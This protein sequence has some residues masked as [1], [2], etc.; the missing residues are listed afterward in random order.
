MHGRN[1]C[2]TFDPMLLLTHLRRFDF[3]QE[4]YTSMHASQI[5]QVSRGCAWAFHAQHVL[6]HN[7][8]KHRVVRRVRK[9]RAASGM[10][11]VHCSFALQS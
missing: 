10:Y 4:W 6:F 1:V 8:C 5:M 11:V 7:P 9:G 2:A 3:R